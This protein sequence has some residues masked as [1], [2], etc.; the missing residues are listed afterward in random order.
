MKVYVC[1]LAKCIIILNFCQH[2]VKLD[3]HGKMRNSFGKL[4]PSD[5]F[6]AM[7]VAMPFYLQLKEGPPPLVVP[8][9]CR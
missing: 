5:W 1:L 8:S 7:S 4:L 3:R 6:M 9:L 2:D